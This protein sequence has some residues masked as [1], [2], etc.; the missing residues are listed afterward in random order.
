MVYNSKTETSTKV[1]DRLNLVFTEVSGSSCFAVAG[2]STNCD[3]IL[4]KLDGISGH[5]ALSKIVRECGPAVLRDYAV[6]DTVQVLWRWWPNMNDHGGPAKVLAIKNTSGGCH[7]NKTA[8]VK[9]IQGRRATTTVALCYI[10]PLQLDAPPPRKRTRKT[11][12]TN[13]L[14]TIDDRLW[15]DGE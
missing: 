10:Q 13:K 11:T 9:Y 1:S 4:G 2:R 8:I 5:M 14:I 15:Q 7:C 6:G 3:N 12:K